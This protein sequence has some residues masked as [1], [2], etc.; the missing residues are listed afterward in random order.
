[1]TNPSKLLALLA[2]SSMLLPLSAYSQAKPVP[3]PNGCADCH[4]SERS[5]PSAAPAAST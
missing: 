2:F 4:S 3:F 5:S 1:M